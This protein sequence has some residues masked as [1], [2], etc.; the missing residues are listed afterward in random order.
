[1]ANFPDTEEF[2][3]LLRQWSRSRRLGGLWWE[4]KEKMRGNAI[5]MWTHFSALVQWSWEECDNHPITC[6][7]RNFALLVPP[8]LLSNEAWRRCSRDQ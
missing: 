6:I 4:E 7:G 5:G 2:E 3:V 8:A 1:M